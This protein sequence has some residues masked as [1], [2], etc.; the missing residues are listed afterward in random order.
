MVLSDV[1]PCLPNF[2]V[3]DLSIFST[4]FLLLKKM[5]EN[6]MCVLLWPAWGIC[7][8]TGTALIGL[9]LLLLDKPLEKEM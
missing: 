4:A 8:M 1:I 7:L 2:R 9:L 3:T 6:Y 5:E